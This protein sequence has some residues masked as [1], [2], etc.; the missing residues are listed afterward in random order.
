M[1]YQKIIKFSKKSQQN[2]SQ[3]DKAIPKE[4]CISPKERQKIID[5]LRL[6]YLNTQN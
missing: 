5:N 4:R 6:V 3:H 1:Q 2:N